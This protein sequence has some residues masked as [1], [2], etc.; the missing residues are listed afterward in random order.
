M[1]EL[2]KFWKNRRSVKREL[3]PIISINYLKQCSE[4]R[5]TFAGHSTCLLSSAWTF[6][7][8]RTTPFRFRW[9]SVR[10]VRDTPKLVNRGWLCLPPETPDISTGTFL[11]LEQKK[12]NACVCVFRLCETD[13]AQFS[14]TSFA[15]K[16]TWTSIGQTI[17]KKGECEV[18]WKTADK[19]RALSVPVNRLPIKEKKK[20][21]KKTKRSRRKRRA[22]LS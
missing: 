6:L 9:R 22:R 15:R 3:T 19:R 8:R 18:R 5:R 13:E 1:M 11:F 4:T 10:I 14:Q 16:K 12:R 21:K 20:K 17:N 2:K 7:K